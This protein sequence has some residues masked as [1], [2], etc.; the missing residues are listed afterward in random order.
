MNTPV[1]TAPDARRTRRTLRT[2]GGLSL[3][4]DVRAVVAGTALLAL[5][6][7]ARPPGRSPSSRSP[8]RSSPGG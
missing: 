5:A 3:R 6:A 8:H 4:L 2:P 1:T 7:A